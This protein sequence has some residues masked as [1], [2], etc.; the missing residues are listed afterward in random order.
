[1][2]HGRASAYADPTWSPGG[3]LHLDGLA[4]Q[5]RFARRGTDTE[6]YPDVSWMTFD[7]LG[8]AAYLLL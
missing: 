2:R 5:I 1:V 7:R 4:L 3:T 8:P 6:F